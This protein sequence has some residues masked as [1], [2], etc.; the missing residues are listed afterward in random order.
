MKNF[1]ILSLFC[2]FF[3][4]LNTEG[5]SASNTR[6]SLAVNFRQPMQKAMTV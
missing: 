2:L 4:A 6:R 3:F 1:D 5:V